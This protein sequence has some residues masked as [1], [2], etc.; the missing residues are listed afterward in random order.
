MPYEL[1]GSAVRRRGEEALFAVL[2]GL[3]LAGAQV[4]QPHQ[5]G[6]GTERSDG[7]HLE[8]AMRDPQVSAKL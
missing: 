3:V 2:A 8:R 5:S 7:E 1:I 4:A 6:G